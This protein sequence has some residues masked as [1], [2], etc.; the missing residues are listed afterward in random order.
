[1]SPCE[2]HRTGPAHSAGR[3]RW[4]VAIVELG[5]RIV[6]ED[7]GRHADRTAAAVLRVVRRQVAAVYSDRLRLV[8]VSV[9]GTV[10]GTKVVQAAGLEWSEVSIDVGQDL[11]L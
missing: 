11:P 4:G 2:Q 10:Q 6:A 5:G 1:M 9:A 3:A 8:S 7:G